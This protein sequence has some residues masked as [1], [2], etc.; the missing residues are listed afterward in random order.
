MFTCIIS[1]ERMQ[2]ADHEILHSTFCLLH[3]RTRKAID[4]CP[5]TDRCTRQQIVLAH[6]QA[7]VHLQQF[8]PSEADTSNSRRLLEADFVGVRLRWQALFFGDKSSLRA[9]TLILTAHAVSV[10]MRPSSFQPI[11]HG[12]I[13]R[14][15]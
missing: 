6:M 1:L 14:L 8:L 2:L 12:F 7:G 9:P 4:G 15:T 13:R 10:I 5:C 3:V 11:A